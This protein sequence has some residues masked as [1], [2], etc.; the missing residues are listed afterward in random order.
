M[1]MKFYLIVLSLLA[2]CLWGT[3]DVRAQSAS[4][5]M[6]VTGKVV[7][8]N[9][10]AVTGASV[11]VVGTTKGTTTGA[12]GAFSLTGVASD[13]RL[14]VNFIGYK[15][16]TV[17][18]GGRTSFNIVLVEEAT[19]VDEVVVVGYGQV[20]KS[21]LT[22]SVASVKAEKLTD[23]PEKVDFF[24]ALPDYD[25]NLFANKKSKSTLDSSREMLSAAIGMLA[26]LPSWS[27][28]MIHDSL[29][30]LAEGLGVKNAL[31]MW[32]VRIAAAGKSVTPGGA[33]EICHILG[34]EETVRRLKL[35]LD[36][37][38]SFS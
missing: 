28:A 16:Q 21:D 4:R 29:V 2:V 30:G 23:I 6:T 5:S 15:T 8:Q 20:K 36:K 34:R 27:E 17:E 9:G 22:G 38:S 32:P 35:G 3:G 18:V 24:D 25:V 33:V 13:A 26:N 10:A 14:A 11:V 37:L 7:D 31:L 12:D 19:A 1:K